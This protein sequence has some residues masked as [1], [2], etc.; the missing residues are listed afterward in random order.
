M[1]K[2]VKIQVRFI[3]FASGDINIVSYIDINLYSFVNG[4]RKKIT[5]L[6]YRLTATDSNSK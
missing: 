6:F 3:P 1:I 4:T 2:T 5:L